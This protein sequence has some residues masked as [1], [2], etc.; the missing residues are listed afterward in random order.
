MPDDANHDFRARRS[1]GGR[2]RNEL[3]DELALARG[4][5]SYP[6]VVQRLARTRLLILDRLLNNAQ[7]HPQGDFHAEALR[8]DEDR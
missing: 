5:G 3:L 6:R 1:R 7:A 4:D 8:L 2:C